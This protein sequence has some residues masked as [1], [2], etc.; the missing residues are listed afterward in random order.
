MNTM[1]IL[2]TNPFRLGSGLFPPYLAGMPQF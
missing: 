2:H 1:N